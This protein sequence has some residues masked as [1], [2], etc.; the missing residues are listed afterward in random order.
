MHKISKQTSL[1]ATQRN[2]NSGLRLSCMLLA[3]RAQYR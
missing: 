2:E 3:A 1:N